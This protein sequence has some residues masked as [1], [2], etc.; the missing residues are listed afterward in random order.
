[1]KGR[2]SFHVP[3]S[4]RHFLPDR[5]YQTEHIKVELKVDPEKKTI[6]GRCSL[7]VRPLRSDLSALHLDA[8]EMQVTGVML[9][10]LRT[11]FDHDGHTLS[12]RT[13]APLNETSHLI[14]VEYS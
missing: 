12:V 11:R 1:M 7:K 13:S 9:D 3:G 4:R 5:E 10:G 2:R 8:A 14:V 6:E